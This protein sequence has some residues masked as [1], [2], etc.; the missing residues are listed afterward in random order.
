MYI[1]VVRLK[2][3]I[4]KKFF[5]VNCKVFTLKMNIKTFFPFF[6]IVIGISILFLSTHRIKESLKPLISQ[7]SGVNLYVEYV[8]NP[9][10]IHKKNIPLLLEKLNGENFDFHKFKVQIQVKN[11]VRIKKI[12][13]R[14]EL[15]I[16]AILN[17]D[18]LN[19]IVIK[20]YK[21]SNKS[22]NDRVLD[23]ISRL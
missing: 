19:I 8:I 7:E 3:R 16:K 21:I 20:N 1:Y 17:S 23:I 22:I 15:H 12:L 4:V 18:L 9:M 13:I 14:Q 6:A 2:I 11:P 10:G 5:F